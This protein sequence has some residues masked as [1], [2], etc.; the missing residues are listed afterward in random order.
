MRLI[1]GDECGWIKECI[2]EL[3]VRNGG[4][5]PSNKEPSQPGLPV[6]VTKEEDNNDKGVLCCQSSGRPPRHGRRRHGIVDMTW[7]VSSSSSSSSKQEDDCFASLQMDGVVQLWQRSSSSS[8]TDKNPSFA[9][10]RPQASTKTDIFAAANATPESV[11][12]TSTTATTIIRPWTKPLGLFSI[13]ATSD[14][15]ANRLCACNARGNVVV[16]KTALDENKDDTISIVNRFTT[17]TALQ[18][19]NNQE[20][21]DKNKFGNAY[22]TACAL[23]TKLGR[24]AVGGQERETTLWDLETCQ[25]VWKAKNLSADPQ[26]LLPPQVWPSSIAF[27]P[28]AHASIGSHILAVGS[29]HKEVRIYDIRDDV[30]QRRPIS[31]TPNGLI[32]HRV[33]SMCL[34]D[35]FHLVVGDATGDLH[36][37]DLRTLG[38]QKKDKSVSTMGRYV[39]P[40][41]SVRDLVAH[42]SLPTMAAVG[43]DRMLRLYD[44]Q[45]RKQIFCLYLKQRLNCVLFGQ[46]EGTWLS[47][48]SKDANDEHNNND[49]DGGIDQEDRVI[50][51]EDSDNDNDNNNDEQG[52]ASD[53][54]QS[55]ERN[56]SPDDNSDMD[57]GDRIEEVSGSDEG[58]EAN[59][60]S[61]DDDDGNDDDDDDDDDDDNIVSTL[62]SRKR[63]K[64]K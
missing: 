33:T 50:D 17:V 51:Y 2:P 20:R 53:A 19:K 24:I 60:D 23:D 30:V 57:G 63:R 14:D 36:T 25:Q 5:T 37:L 39:G 21:E 16:L 1:T 45:T 38:K 55:Q 59:D 8:K 34:V 7:V 61:S 4:N 56:D 9:R 26:T 42:E 40:A 49:D 10:Y 44:T 18:N 35:P 15:T 48:L 22:I 32:E 31:F 11:T 64:V 28:H 29:A 6:E 62:L 27:L 13:P 52:Q 46:E 12:T 58:S 43:L 3:A 54:E 47:S 41:G